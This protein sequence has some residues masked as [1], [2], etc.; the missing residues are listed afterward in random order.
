LKNKEFHSSIFDIFIKKLLPKF[1][2]VTI[3]KNQLQQIL[4]PET[5][6]KVEEFI[7]ILGNS[8]LL[9]LREVETYWFSIPNAGAFIKNC[10]KGRQELLKL[11]ERQ[12]WKEMLE[13]DLERRKLKMT[14]LPVDFI[15]KDLIGLNFIESVNTSAGRLI[16]LKDHK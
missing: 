7:T 12:K 16:R 13:K 3:S 9:I 6:E 10:I 5:P 2:D 15:I 4:C 8:G 11:L 1:F 14:S